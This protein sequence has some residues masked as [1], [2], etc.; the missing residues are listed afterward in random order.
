MTWCP[1]C[2]HFTLFYTKVNGVY[3]ESRLGRCCNSHKRGYTNKVISIDKVQKC[4]K[5]E[6]VV[7]SEVCDGQYSLSDLK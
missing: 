4:G 2:K 7:K 6:R 5:Y 1:T 3:Y